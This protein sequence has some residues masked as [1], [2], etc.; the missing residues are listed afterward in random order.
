MNDAPVLFIPIYTDEDVNSAL[1][2][3][4]RKRGHNAQSAA[5]ADMLE[6]SD[7][8]QLLYAASRN[9]AI[10]TRNE[11]DFVAL[12]WQWAGQNRD[13]PGIIISQPF[14]QEQFGELLR[15]TLRLLDT[16][17]IDDMRNAFVYLS[18]FR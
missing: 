13:H 4:L 9:M 18:Q 3:E 17:T 16:L 1:A 12:A 7:E 5:E 6:Q 10:M 8:S 2:A 15:Q 14:S 11:K